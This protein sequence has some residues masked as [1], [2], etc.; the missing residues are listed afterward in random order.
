MMANL[1]VA[2]GV[3]SRG[4]SCQSNGADLVIQAVAFRAGL[5]TVEIHH[6]ML[7]FYAHVPIWLKHAAHGDKKERLQLQ[8]S[9]IL[10]VF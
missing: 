4:E 5:L 2:T 8:L 1:H 10:T 9:G 7:G 3:K 6:L